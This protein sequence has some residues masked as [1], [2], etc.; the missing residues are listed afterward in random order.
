MRLGALPVAMLLLLSITAQSA[1]PS[2]GFPSASSQPSVAAN[3]SFPV[4]EGVVCPQDLDA[5]TEALY[6]AIEGSEDPRS[7]IA[8]LLS[9]VAPLRELGSLDDLDGR[10]IPSFEVDLIAQGFR[11]GVYW[12]LDGLLLDLS[13]AGATLGG[14]PVTPQRLSTALGKALAGPGRKAGQSRRRGAP[15][16]PGAAIVVGLARARAARTRDAPDKVLG[17]RLLDPLQAFLIL[18]AFTR[19]P[20]GTA[21]F[22][23]LAE[24]TPR[25]NGGASALDWIGLGPQIEE[26]VDP[27]ELCGRLIASST[28]ISVY[29]PSTEIAGQAIDQASVWLRSPRAPGPFEARFDAFVRNRLAA[30]AP[31]LHQLAE[32][33]GCDVPQGVGWEGVRVEWWVP[34]QV[35]PLGSLDPVFATTDAS[36]FARTTFRAADDP[37]PDQGEPPEK[38]SVELGVVGAK[39]HGSMPG[40]VNASTVR[41]RVFGLNERPKPGP[42]LDS[43]SMMVRWTEPRSFSLEFEGRRFPVRTRTIGTGATVDVE[44]AVVGCYTDADGWSFAGELIPAYDYGSGPAAPLQETVQLVGHRGFPELFTVQGAGGGYTLEFAD[45]FGEPRGEFSMINGFEESVGPFAMKVTRLE[46][47]CPD[48][49]R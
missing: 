16:A 28:M 21:A 33:A 5:A 41:Q 45:A 2:P 36:G 37:T 9:C 10:S 31:A 23:L 7:R 26:G 39:V 3:L 27:G 6:A 18:Q 42:L 14:R 30:E 24:G 22:G 47:T 13:T 4:P 32:A 17:D 1:S 29:G 34:P 15:V 46:A 12:E 11:N 43:W 25:A 40:F 8:A 35:K 20:T 38:G 44:G 48:A 19:G 49:D